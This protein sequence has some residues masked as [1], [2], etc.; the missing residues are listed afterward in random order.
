M[1]RVKSLFDPVDSTDGIRLYVE[2]GGLTRDLVDW[3]KVDHLLFNAAP[4]RKL[5]DWF[6][7]H[8]RQYDVF[9]GQYHQWLNKSKFLNAID[10]LAAAAKEET[11]TLLH[12]GDDAGQNTATA[13]ADFLSDRQG[14]TSSH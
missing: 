2:P 1:I 7:K 8:P 6:E 11:Y 13:L 3:C 12:T 10:E 4:P 14:W 9:R 5:V